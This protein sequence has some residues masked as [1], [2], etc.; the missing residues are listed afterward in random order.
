MTSFIQ[1]ESSEIVEPKKYIAFLACNR[2]T[3]VV[4]TFSA[5]LKCS[6]INEYHFLVFLDQPKNDEGIEA[7]HSIKNF[8]IN[9]LDTKKFKTFTLDIADKNLGVWTSKLKIFSNTFELGSDFTLLL[10]D[11]VLLRPDALDFCSE[12]C[13]FI[14]NADELITVSLYSSNLVELKN[15]SYSKAL[16]FV[17]ENPDV[18]H[19]WGLR[20]W[21]FPWGIGLSKKVY[22][23][24]MM[25]GWNGNDQNMG[26]LLQRVNG[27]DLFP[28]ISRSDHIGKS[29]SV[30][31]EFEVVRH[32]NFEDSNY[33]NRK[34][35]IT[36]KPMLQLEQGINRAGHF[37]SNLKND[38]GLLENRVKIL[39][40]DP[41]F[42]EKIGELKDDNDVLDI[43]ASYVDPLWLGDI[44]SIKLYNAIS[45][46]AA[47]VTVLLFNE[48]E[49]LD[50][51]LSKLKNQPTKVL[52]GLDKEKIF[53]A[54]KNLI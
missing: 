29:K 33:L 54:L 36:S 24:F 9:N 37:F 15:V 31:G 14:S 3:M 2:F 8:F 43:D 5:L 46:I 1:G 19:E 39:Y 40:G 13:N 52:I 53:E 47:P 27:Y 49:I 23:S 7:F 45:R 48:S 4:E 25:L 50:F 30:N 44:D 38:L 51:I 11:D 42:L 12:A 28:I 22:E 34:F 35:Q 20:R 18:F 16:Q 41:I 6:G 17:S 26:Q 10:E 21:P 32:I